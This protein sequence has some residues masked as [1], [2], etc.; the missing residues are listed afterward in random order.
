VVRRAAIELRSGP[1]GRFD[2]EGT[3]GDGVDTMDDDADVAGAV[4][5]GLNVA[6]RD[7]NSCNRFSNAAV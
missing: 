2:G 7:C 1:G 6:W 4:V 3:G 5:G